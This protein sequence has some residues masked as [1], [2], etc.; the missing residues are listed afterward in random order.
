M[1]ATLTT[2]VLLGLALIASSAQ[3]D[4]WHE[5]DRPTVARDRPDRA[6][7]ARPERLDRALERIRPGNDDVRFQRG[8]VVRARAARSSTGSFVNRMQP[9]QNRGQQL[10]GRANPSTRMSC[11]EADACSMSARG[12]QALVQQAA[13]ISRGGGSFVNKIQPGYARG[14]G[15]L[16]RANGSE[17]MTQAGEGYGDPYMSPAGARAIWFKAAPA[18]NA[19]G[20]YVNKIQDRIEEAKIKAM[21][22]AAVM[23]YT[24][25][26]ER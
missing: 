23:K 12:A 14:K 13:A 18:R 3:A 19:G 9:N 6:P 21:I 24:H 22:K 11:N 5:R 20:T 4:R 26:S 15:L 17:R 7:V 10:L 8:D 16:G 25:A 1:R 2:P